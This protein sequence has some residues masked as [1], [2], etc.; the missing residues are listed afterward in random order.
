MVALLYIMSPPSPPLNWKDVSLGNDASFRNIIQK[1]ESPFCPP[2]AP[3]L[4]SSPP[5]RKSLLPVTSR[6]SYACSGCCVCMCIC[7]HTLYT[8]ILSPS[9]LILCMLH[10]AGSSSLTLYLVVIQINA[11]IT[12]STL[13]IEVGYPIVWMNQNLTYS[14]RM[15]I[16]LLPVFGGYKQGSLIN[17]MLTS[18]CTCENISAG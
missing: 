17:L 13:F 10:A 9:V 3:Q 11:E 18:F 12:F 7:T 14:Q 1:L 6:E 8:H 16:T 4:L 5:W 2:T 15:D